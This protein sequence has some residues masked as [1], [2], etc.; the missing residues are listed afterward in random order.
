MNE[1]EIWFGWCAQNV[2]KILIYFYISLCVYIHTGIGSIKS[3]W[4]IE[5]KLQRNSCEISEKSQSLFRDPIQSPYLHFPNS[6]YL[7]LISHKKVSSR[8]PNFQIMIYPPIPCHF[9]LFSFCLAHPPAPVTLKSRQGIKL[10]RFK[11]YPFTTLLLGI[12]CFK[13]TYTT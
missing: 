6:S 2:C 1:T 5:E 13:L 10:P 4:M 11:N 3:N 8:W 12:R 9:F 7:L